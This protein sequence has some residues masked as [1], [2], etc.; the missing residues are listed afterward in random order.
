MK[1]VLIAGETEKTSN[2]ENAMRHL[3]VHAKTSLHV[4]STCAYDGLILPGGGDIDPRLFGQLPNGTRFFDSELDRI[5]ME[6]LRAFVSDRKPVLGICKGCSLLI[7]ILEG[8]WYSI[9][10]RARLTNIRKG[11]GS[12]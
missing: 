6:I 10:R 11:I 2:Y 7:F 8:I 3:G 1:K 12:I 5:Q 4:P 9:F